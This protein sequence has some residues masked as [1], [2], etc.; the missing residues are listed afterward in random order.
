M[1]ERFAIKA[2]AHYGMKSSSAKARQCIDLLII[3]LWDGGWAAKN[4][5]PGGLKSTQ[6]SNIRHESPQT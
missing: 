2:Q 3:V 5:R 1:T 4:V 6:I